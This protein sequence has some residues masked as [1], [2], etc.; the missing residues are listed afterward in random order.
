[1]WPMIFVIILP[2]FID[3]FKF[4]FK[5]AEGQG[6]GKK[7]L[8]MIICGMVAVGLINPYG[9]R[10]IT[11][12]YTSYGFDEINYFVPE[13]SAA[14]INSLLGLEIFSTIFLVFFALYIYK[15][16]NYR[17]RYYL[18]ALGT[19]YMAIS[20]VRNYSFFIICGIIPLS[21]YLK[22]MNFELNDKNS[23][24]RAFFIRKILIFML[25]VSLSLTAI[26]KYTQY[27][28]V[29]HQDLIKGVECLEKFNKSEVRLYTG[30]HSGSYLEFRG[31]KVYIDPRADAFLKS[32]N[33]K[34]DIMKEYT[35]MQAGKLYY[36]EVLNKYNFTHLLV[37]NDDILY[38][39]LAYDKDYKLIYS[40]GYY[41]IYENERTIR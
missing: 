2:Y 34:Q 8:V 7:N 41:K 14:N 37:E 33:K 29:K 19:A 11:Y 32:N 9:I 3:S 27:T 40:S 28:D 31:F 18:L 12:L 15:K 21:Y 39:Y 22:D 6:Y 36:K 30:Y 5:F 13:M 38:N 23:D 20:S 4:K 10:A 1:M 35:Q 16:G 17:L 25:L 26:Y 24:K